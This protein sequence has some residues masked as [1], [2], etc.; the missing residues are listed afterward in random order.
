MA[1][2]ERHGDG[3]R[4]RYRLDDRSIMTEPGFDTRDAAQDRIDDLNYEQRKGTWVDPRA[5]Q[6]LLGEWVTTWSAA[7]DVSEGTWAKYNSHLA[8]HILPKFGDTAIGDIQRLAVKGWVKSLRRTL[9]EATVAD[10]VTI[11]SMILGEAVEE[12]L[13]TA[14]P[15]RKLRI[16][17]DGGPE[18]PHAAGWQVVRIAERSRRR[19]DWLLIITAAY[20]GMRWGELAAL[21][22]I[23]LHFDEPR[24]IVDPDKGALHEVRGT[25]VLGPPKTAAS[26]RTVHLP[27]FLA[28]LLREHLDNHDHRFVFTGADGGLLRRS[29]FRNRVWLPAVEGSKT[30]GLSPLFPGLHFHDLRHTQKTWL[31]E[32]G[33]PEVAQAARM[34]HRLPGVRGIYS[35]V[36]Q[37]MI[38]LLLA[39]LERRWEQTGSTGPVTTT[40]A[41]M[42]SRSFA[43]NLL[44]GQ[45]KACR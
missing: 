24:I 8:N 14:N 43:P 17:R 15:C 35:H 4:V 25:L 3:F 18:R 45:Q 5:S 40:E 39:A 26:V 2:I 6:T 37:A 16:N 23:N 32:D 21:Q 33:V 13:I 7:H 38:D 42:G 41:E 34:G 22:T 30:R 31:I 9:A 10:V 36:S 11:L 19:E 29:N 27:P 28:A 1:W 20:T 44:P 12:D